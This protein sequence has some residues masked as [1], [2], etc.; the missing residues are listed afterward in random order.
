MEH[1]LYLISKKLHVLK[2]LALLPVSTILR[3]HTK[4]LNGIKLYLFH[5]VSYESYNILFKH[6]SYGRTLL[7]TE[8]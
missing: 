8:R 4:L 6:F 5:S 1:P 3:Q 2:S 7:K